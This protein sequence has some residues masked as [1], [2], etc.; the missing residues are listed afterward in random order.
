MR[1]ETTTTL[2][3]IRH[4]RN[5]E[6]REKL[7]VTTEIKYIRHQHNWRNHLEKI[8][9]DRGA[10]ETWGDQ[11]NDGESEGI[12]TNMPSDLTYEV[13]FNA[14]YEYKTVKCASVIPYSPLMQ[15]VYVYVFQ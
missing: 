14:T 12:H 2:R 15:C 7:K 9:S 1:F 8:Q 13:H 5:Y 11:N 10:H 4:R 6:A 3:R